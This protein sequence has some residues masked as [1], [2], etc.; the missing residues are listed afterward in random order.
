MALTCFGT[1]CVQGSAK[2]LSAHS[3]FCTG[4]KPFE[5]ELRPRILSYQ[6]TL[7]LMQRYR[8]MVTVVLSSY[9]FR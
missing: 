4:Y 2:R 3:T 1:V 7:C 8:S 9:K 5:Y 6:C